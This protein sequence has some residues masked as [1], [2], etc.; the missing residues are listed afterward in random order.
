MAW[1]SGLSRHVWPLSLAVSLVAAGCGGPTVP[2]RGPG[3][4]PQTGT[5]GGSGADGGDVT[6]TRFTLHTADGQDVYVLLGRDAV[7]GPRGPTVNGTLTFEDVS[8]PIDVTIVSASGGQ[9]RVYTWTGVT[10]ADF[11][12]PSFDAP[13]PTTPIAGVVTGGSNSAGVRRA[14]AHF[15]SG[16]TSTTTDVPTVMG[17][18]TFELQTPH[19][20][21]FWASSYEEQSGNVFS[22][23][24]GLNRDP[25][26]HPAT[27]EVTVPLTLSFNS[28]LTTTVTNAGDFSGLGGY[29]T[30]AF[31]PAETARVNIAFPEARGSFLGSTGL[32]PAL[33]R[34][35]PFDDPTYGVVVSASTSAALTTAVQRGIAA[36]DDGASVTLLEHAALSGNTPTAPSSLVL[37]F[38][39][40]VVESLEQFVLTDGTIDANGSVQGDATFTWT[41]LFGPTSGER[42]WSPFALPAASGAPEALSVT[43]GAAC[44]YTVRQDGCFTAI[45]TA[46]D[47]P[48]LGYT[49]AL[50]SQLSY[51]ALL[52]R[53]GSRV[54]TAW[55]RIEFE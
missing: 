16:A 49:A 25:L 11:E 39:T 44:D 41:V 4:R 30:Y 37:T 5:G 20:G 24:A 34:S 22:R 26:T 6:E 27:T 2:P 31:A 10:Q 53:G 42:T 7:D 17:Q 55:S 18:R 43:G 14:S 33:P 1:F 23:K 8:F 45:L 52:E 48:G 28:T 32:L 36:L 13:Q 38:T 54:S 19:T 40:P 35:V 29:V 46:F 12:V 21:E 3:Y 9:T 47:V 50:Q 51:G 15:L